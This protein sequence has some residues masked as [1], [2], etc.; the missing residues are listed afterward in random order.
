M[1]KWRYGSSRSRHFALG[2]I[3]GKFKGDFSFGLPDGTGTWTVDKLPGDDALPDGHYLTITGKWKGLRP[4]PVEDGTGQ[5]N[6]YGEAHFGQ[7][8][9]AVL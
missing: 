2:A 6:E 1:C 3:A 5:A 4:A 7:V 8:T 9:F